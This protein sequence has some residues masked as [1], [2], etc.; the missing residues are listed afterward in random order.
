MKAISLKELTLNRNSY[1]FGISPGVLNNCDQVRY[2]TMVMAKQGFSL[3]KKMVL[4]PRSHYALAWAVYSRCSHNVASYAR[5]YA[6]TCQWDRGCPLQQNEQQLVLSLHCMVG[7]GQ[8]SRPNW[9][10]DLSHESNTPKCFHDFCRQKNYKHQFT[11]GS[12]RPLELY[13]NKGGFISRV[14]LMCKFD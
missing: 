7:V 5:M 1:D 13:R 4:G 6:R 12:C 8:T 10:T 11:P 3:Y 9:C 2:T 14:R